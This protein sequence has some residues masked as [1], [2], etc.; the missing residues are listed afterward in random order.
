MLG[1]SKKWSEVLREAAT[2]TPEYIFGLNSFLGRYVGQH[3][4]KSNGI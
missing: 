4:E 3:V 2:I 1:G